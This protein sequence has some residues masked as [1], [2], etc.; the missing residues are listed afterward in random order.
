MSVVLLNPGLVSHW[1]LNSLWSKPVENS[2][3]R[4]PGETEIPTP[5]I[6]SAD[7]SAQEFLDLNLGNLR[8]VTP[9]NGTI[10]PG[11]ALNLVRPEQS[12][13]PGQ[14]ST[15][16]LSNLRDSVNSASETFGET[17]GG[18]SNFEENNLGETPLTNDVQPASTESY[19]QSYTDAEADYGGESTEIAPDRP[20]SV[21]F[22]APTILEPEVETGMESVSASRGYSVVTPYTSDQLLDQAQTIVPDAYLKNTEEGAN[23]QFGVFSDPDSAAALVEQLQEQGISV[24]VVPA[25]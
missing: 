20:P 4:S 18:E 19:S 5:P 2:E 1:G 9:Q 13:L 16:L 15:G 8:T 14:P 6:D 3:E 7:L 11:S 10:T 21:S 12:T 23:I 22:P 25:E 24:E 17:Q